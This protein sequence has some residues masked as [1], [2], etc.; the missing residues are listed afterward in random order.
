MTALTAIVTSGATTRTPITPTSEVRPSHVGRC[1]RALMK[2]SAAMRILPELFHSRDLLPPLQQ[3]LLLAK[4]AVDVEGHQLELAKSGHACGWFH[5][6]AQR[7]L[8]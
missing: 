8:V 2:G 3:A 6:R 4:R 5:V 7:V 1:V